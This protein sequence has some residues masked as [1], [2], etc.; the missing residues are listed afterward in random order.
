MSNVKLGIY[1]A[2]I[3][4]RL[5]ALMYGSGY[6][7]VSVTKKNPD[8]AYFFDFAPEM[9]ETRGLWDWTG[10][11]SDQAYLTDPAVMDTAMCEFVTVEIETLF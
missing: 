11:R 2:T 1:G 10:M 8:I 7:F 5:L 9:S 4:K 3:N 6:N